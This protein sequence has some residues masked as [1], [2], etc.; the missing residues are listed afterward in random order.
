MV[1]SHLCSGVI[2]GGLSARPSPHKTPRFLCY[3]TRTFHLHNR[4]LRLLPQRCLARLRLRTC[5]AIVHGLRLEFSAS[6]TR[7]CNDHMQCMCD[8][9]MPQQCELRIAVTLQGHAA[10]TQLAQSVLDSSMAAG[11]SLVSRFGE[12]LTGTRQLKTHTSPQ[13]IRRA[14]AEREWHV[15]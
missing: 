11:L 2:S 9:F 10:S 7:N 13:H 6:C 12:F 5:G 8:A 3:G 15:G 14:S 4:W 1:L